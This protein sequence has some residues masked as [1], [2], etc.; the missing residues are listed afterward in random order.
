MHLF[1]AHVKIRD[2]ALLGTIL[3]FQLHNHVLHALIVGRLGLNFGHELLHL[4]KEPGIVCG[5]T[6]LLPFKYS[7]F[8]F[9]LLDTLY[10][11]INFL[12]FLIE[13]G[14]GLLTLIFQTLVLLHLSLDFLALLLE[15]HILLI[16][17][18]LHLLLHFHYLLLHLSNL[19][20]HGLL[21]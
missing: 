3:I 17:L 2:V 5:K 13:F 4:C 15:L 21:L 1:D 8:F 16:T 7:H 11:I 20:S 19:G 14:A 18:H 9:Q 10:C 12:F 6:L